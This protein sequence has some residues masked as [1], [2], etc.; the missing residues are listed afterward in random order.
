MWASADGVQWERVI[1]AAPYG[2]RGNTAVCPYAGRL[3]VMGG[4]FAR[5]NDPPE[6]G[7]EDRTSLNDVWCSEDGIAWHELPTPEEFKPRHEPTVYVYDD[8]LWIVAGNSR[9]V[10]N[11]VW[12]VT[13]REE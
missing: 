2:A 10:L 1:E 5:A 6:Q 9:P 3:W 12:R 4:R 13:I 11:D 7:Y 8:S